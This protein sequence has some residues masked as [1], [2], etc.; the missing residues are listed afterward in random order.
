M[1]A[2]GFENLNKYD[3]NDSNCDLSM[4]V[5]EI[6]AGCGWKSQKNLTK[7]LQLRNQTNHCRAVWTTNLMRYA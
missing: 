1:V 5:H 7:L 6:V 3:D 2:V 4:Y